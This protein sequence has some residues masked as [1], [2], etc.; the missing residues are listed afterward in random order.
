ME[1]SF[2]THSHVASVRSVSSSKYYTASAG[3]DETIC[4]YDMRYRR[5][6]GKLIHHNGT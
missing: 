2:A 1:K 4:L 6:C 5:E 3:A